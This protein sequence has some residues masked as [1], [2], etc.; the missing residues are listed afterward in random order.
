[1]FDKIGAMGRVRTTGTQASKKQ[2]HK[3][4]SGHNAWQIVGE[5][6]TGA[7]STQETC[8]WLG[9]SRSRLYQLKA[10]WKETQPDQ[11]REGW[12][13]QRRNTGARQF[14]DVI[15]EFLRDQLHYISEKSEFFRGHFNFA[16]LADQCQQR[17]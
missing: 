10:R 7:R 9:I 17:F 4:L 13:Y 16:F 5:F 6:A 2:L 3:R 11:A 12:L 8:A 14:P 1:V 15:Q